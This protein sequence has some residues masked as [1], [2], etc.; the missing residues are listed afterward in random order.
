MDSSQHRNLLTKALAS[1]LNQSRVGLIG[2]HGLDKPRETSQNYIDVRTGPTWPIE[3]LRH[4]WIPNPPSPQS[5]GDSSWSSHMDRPTG[6][7]GVLELIWLRMLSRTLLTQDRIWSLALVMAP[8]F[9]LKERTTL[10]WG[11]VELGWVRP[12]WEERGS[13][14][15][16]SF[17]ESEIGVPSEVR[18]EDSS[19]IKGKGELDWKSALSDYF[20]LPYFKVTLSYAAVEPSKNETR[21]FIEIHRNYSKREPWRLQADHSILS[22]SDFKLL[23]GALTRWIKEEC[24]LTNPV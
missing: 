11:P 2:Q 10:F 3:N 21:I 9:Q 13:A 7:E 15:G 4:T 19:V 23:T 14:D 12:P 17:E 1:A 22:Q 16:L 5:W 6:L 8:S 24:P 18:R 20:I